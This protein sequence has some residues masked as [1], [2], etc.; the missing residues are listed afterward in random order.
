MLS[1]EFI[2]EVKKYLK[3]DIKNWEETL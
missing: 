2:K 3:K 1:K